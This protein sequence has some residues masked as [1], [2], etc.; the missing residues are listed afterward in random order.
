MISYRQADLLES[1]KDKEQSKTP[2]VFDVTFY[3]DEHQDTYERR[4]SYHNT[5]PHVSDYNDEPPTGKSIDEKS[6]YVANLADNALRKTINTIMRKGDGRIDSHDAEMIMS[7]VIN[8]IKNDGRIKRATGFD[9]EEIYDKSGDVIIEYM[10]Q[11][12]I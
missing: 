2:I 7:G 4:Y 12:T 3:Y 8:I 11:V 6:E 9:S 5:V 1:L 10:I